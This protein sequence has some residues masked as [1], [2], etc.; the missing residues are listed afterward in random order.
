LFE[1]V[2]AGGYYCYPA[3]AGDPWLDGL[4]RKPAFTKV[5]QKAEAYH[6][7]ALAAF[8]RRGGFEILGATV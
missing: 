4:R 6:Q 3:M 8:E 1:R 5:L 2:V 7:E